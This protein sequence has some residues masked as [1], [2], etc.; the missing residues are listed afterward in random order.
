MSQVSDLSC[1]VHVCVCARVRLRV[2]SR[3]A[4]EELGSVRQT[5]ATVVLEPHFIVTPGPTGAVVAAVHGTCT[6]SATGGASS[7]SCG[8]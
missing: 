4:G 7:L 8:T 1:R 3:G 2:E 6:S 5:Q